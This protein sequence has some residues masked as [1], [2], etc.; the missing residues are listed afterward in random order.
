MLQ[1]VVQLKKML[2][3]GSKFSQKYFVY[4]IAGIFKYGYLK[5]GIKNTSCVMKFL[6]KVCVKTIHA[7]KPNPKSKI[8]YDG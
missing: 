2:A 5:N 6:K 3:S 4:I 7:I 1:F 8:N